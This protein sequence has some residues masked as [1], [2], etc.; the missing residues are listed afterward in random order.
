[1]HR[2]PSEPLSP[3]REKRASY[4]E[5]RRRAFGYAGAGIRRMIAGEAH[6]KIHLIAAI[7]VILA[8][9]IFAISPLE[10]CVV[11]LC[12][13]TVFMAEAFNTAI[14]KLADKVSREK[15]PL[16]GAAKDVGAGA[17]LVMAAGAA[18]AGL[19]IFLPKLLNLLVD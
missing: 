18:A 4:L 7:L 8:G 1:M 11:I 3:A 2:S 9:I 16:I 12:I 5:K 19:V 17:V 14:E 13:A 15:D 10:W 6:A